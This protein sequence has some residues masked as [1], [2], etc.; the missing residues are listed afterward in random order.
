M[1]QSP[2]LTFITLPDHPNQLTEA[3]SVSFVTMDH[4]TARF[5]RKKDKEKDEEAPDPAARGGS[6]ASTS[7]AGSLAPP[8]ANPTANPTPP[9]TDAASHSPHGGLFSGLSNLRVSNKKEK[10]PSPAPSA[11]PALEPSSSSLGIGPNN[12]SLLPADGDM[13]N[14]SLHGVNSPTLRGPKPQMPFFLTLSDT[15]IK[16]KFQDLTWNERMRLS[17]GAQGGPDHEFAPVTL[18]EAKYLDRYTNIQPWENNR[19]RLHVPDNKVDYIN[20]SPIIAR[21][22]MRPDE[23][24]PFRYI[25]MQG[26]KINTAEHAWRMVAEQL[27]SPAVIV[28]LTEPYEH[29]NEK[30]FPYFPADPRAPAIE[31]GLE[32]EFEDGFRATVECTSIVKKCEGAIQVR[33]L[34]LKVEGRSD[35]IVWHLLYRKWPDF[36]A[37]RPEDWASFFEL[38]KFSRRL[39][40]GAFDNPRIIHCSAGVGRSGTFIALETLMREIDSGNM[41]L[42]DPRLVTHKEDLVYNMVNNLRKQR[43]QMVQAETQFAFIYHVLRQHWLEKNEFQDEKVLRMTRSNSRHTPTISSPRDPRNSSGRHLLSEKPPRTQPQSLP[44]SRPKPPSRAHSQPQPR[45]D[46]D[47]SD[48]SAGGAPLHN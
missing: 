42:L 17:G 24:P 5:K 11:L 29:F 37:P 35:M 1:S 44:Q 8:A 30:C 34:N 36:G 48:D 21:S 4:L 40:T 6:P 10:G 15:E 33:K 47:S 7:S 19:V 41:N 16:N 43:K 31:I 39:N 38:M 18:P 26:P 20:A 28:M 3:K 25:A 32:D 27:S 23:Q 22:P 12:Q 46:G 9:A 14:R 2:R 13:A 45:D